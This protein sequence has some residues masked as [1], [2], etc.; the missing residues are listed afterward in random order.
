MSGTARELVLRFLDDLRAAETAAS[1]VLAAWIAVCEVDG[2]RGGLRSIA[3]REAGHAALLADRLREL[4]GACTAVVAEPLRAAALARFGSPAVADEEKL[5]VLALRYPD[6]ATARRPI[7]R[8]LEELTD[9]TETRELLRLIADAEAAT[10]TW[11]RSQIASRRHL[12]TPPAL[13]PPVLVE[14]PSAPPRPATPARQ[15]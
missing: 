4:G 12:P 9:D 5:G 10:V 15:S 8:V 11:L 14:S 1:E 2:L 6:E 7:E 13:R 3:A